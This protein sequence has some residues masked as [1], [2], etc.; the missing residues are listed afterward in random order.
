MTELVIG[1]AAAATTT[2]TASMASVD[3]QHEPGKSIYSGR[4]S[5][6][7][8]S[9]INTD[10]FSMGKKE[11]RNKKVKSL[12][13][14]D[15]DNDNEKEKEKKKK[16]KKKKK[17]G[18]ETRQKHKDTKTIDVSIKDFSKR[19][20]V[21][22]LSRKDI[23]LNLKE[24][25][26]YYENSEMQIDNKLLNSELT[27][28][29]DIPY[30]KQLRTIRYD[31]ENEN[32]HRNQYNKLLHDTIEIYLKRIGRNF[33][34]I[35]K[36]SNEIL[37][38]K[39]EKYEK[40]WELKNGGPLS[41]IPKQIE[42]E[43][44]KAL[45]QKKT[46]EEYDEE[47]LKKITAYQRFKELQADLN[48]GKK[49]LEM[50][51]FPVVY[52][53]PGTPEFEYLSNSIRLISQRR[54][55]CFTIDVEAFELNNDI[56]TEFGISIYDPRE[57]F[58]SMTPIIKTYHLIVKEVLA[59]RNCK[60]ICDYKDCYLNGESLVLTLNQCVEFIQ[61]L[62][63]YYMIPKTEEDRTWSRAFIGHHVQGDLEWLNKIGIIIPEEDI[64]YDLLNC[65]IKRNSFKYFA[66]DTE[67]LYKRTYGEISCNLGKILRL[68]EIPH[69]FLHNAGNDSYYTLQL[70]L[71]LCDFNFR[72]EKNLDDLKLI[73]IKIRNWIKRE[74]DE[75]KVVPLSY[76]ISVIE[77]STI[78]TRSN[79]DKTGE[80]EEEEEEE[81]E[82]VMIIQPKEGATESR[83]KGKGR[84][85]K[86]VR[87][88][89]QKDLVAQTEFGGSKWFSRAKDAFM[90]T[91]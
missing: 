47:L 46:L 51:H 3:I 91:L 41:D 39:I 9:Q 49:K 30:F 6:D 7:P 53:L 52:T 83:G 45:K 15:N 75:P 85:P 43:V 80:E 59:L 62:I 2:A 27:W 63:N 42:I 81:E 73:G 58:F 61:S 33:E 77:A 68:L 57:N 78:P 86:R 87:I 19:L 1:T 10:A 56:I 79:K 54:T 21:R 18:K 23:K 89:K 82:A 34:N 11:K 26:N 60:W 13:S 64:N 20:N 70:L 29:D 36:E 37:H 17:K 76:A 16:K 72:N 65:S 84:R 28:L 40:E 71:K 32:G 31:D 48:T 12:S 24:M 38:I 66:L 5:D 50:D 69:A 25:S 35:A 74:K 4:D 44:I 55:I 14:E 90:S 22:G 88:R 8:V 67:L